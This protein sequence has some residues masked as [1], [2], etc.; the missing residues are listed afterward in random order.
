MGGVEIL[1]PL[2]F[3]AAIVLIVQIQA[4]KRIHMTLIQHGKDAS[5]L[6]TDKDAN[7]TL[8]VGLL[9]IGI[10]VGI[11]LGN[12]LTA[13]NYMD[14]EPAYFSMMLIFGG[15]SLLVYYFLIKKNAL[16]QL[17]NSE[18]KAEGFTKE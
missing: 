2:G 16:N 6:K 8:K 5:M 3:F 18:E 12:I 14:E 11:L 13:G 15:T 10:S 17:K 1:V 4:R 9:M 7:N